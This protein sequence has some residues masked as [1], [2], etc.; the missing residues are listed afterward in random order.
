M[1]LI[2]RKVDQL[3][4]SSPSIWQRRDGNVANTT[5]FPSQSK[6]PIAHQ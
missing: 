2:S 3:S 5:I 4:L 6:V 1:L